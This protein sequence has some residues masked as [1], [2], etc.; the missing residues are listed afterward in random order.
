MENYSTLYIE[1]VIIHEIIR[2]NASDQKKPPI[3]SEIESEL[4]D[5][6]RVFLKDKVIHTV[7]SSKAQ[8]VI[9][10]KLSDSPVPS[11]IQTLLIG[12]YENEEFITFSK[13]IAD[14]LNIIQSGRSPGGFIT[15]IYGKNQNRKVLGILKI[16]REQGARLE[17]SER[18]GKKTYEITSIKDLV[19]SPNTKLLKIGFFS[20]DED[21][22]EIEGKI[23]DNQ[24]TGK[25]DV[26]NFFI[27]SF[28]GCRF[29][30]DPAI[31]TKNFF[32]SS[33]HFIK[34]KIEDPRIQ[35]RYKLHLQSYISNEARLINP[36]KFASLNLETA[37][38]KVYED[39]LLD[40][41]V[42]VGEFIRDISYIASK[43][44]KMAL[45]FENGIQIVG[46][47]EDFEDNVLIEHL[48]DGRTKALVESKLKGI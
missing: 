26:A 11:I 3:Y 47:Q 9:F 46:N 10:D 27:K 41:E 23:C 44:E 4:N 19:L 1:N 12:N 33:I 34:E 18:E 40:K 43:I 25:G 28:L 48:D 22:E 20:Q 6:I 2:Q 30:Q 14:H 37:H 38:R 45:E 17:Q 13:R 8:S 7:G 39:Y 32:N 42:G 36:R 24:L 16:E 31:Q 21:A 29:K 15:I 35:S 5:E